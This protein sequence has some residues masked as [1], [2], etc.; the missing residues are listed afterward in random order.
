MGVHIEGDNPDWAL[1]FVPKGR[2]IRLWVYWNQ[3]ELSPY[4]YNFEIL[5]RKFSLFKD[6]K[7]ILSLRNAPEWNRLYPERGE[8]S[9]PNKL[10]YVNFS[11]IIGKRYN[12]YGLE[13]WNEPEPLVT[14]ELSHFIGSFSDT[15]EGGKIYAELVKAV[16]EEY[17]NNNLPHKI[18]SGALAISDKV[19]TFWNSAIKNNINSYS[20]A[21]SFHS[22]PNLLLDYS[23]T[24]NNYNLI[25]SLS[26][27]KELLLT[28]T[29]YLY[30]S[31]STTNE[32]KQAEYL[33]Y[34][35]ERL[36]IIIIWYTLGRNGWRNS[37][38][39][40]LDMR[41]KPVYYSFVE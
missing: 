31:T 34:I 29:S 5:D 8:G 9:P 37:D 27:G 32:A 24:I 22:Y 4:N 33:Q 16:Y 10:E 21:I 39:L 14:G 7:I 35:K 11:K 40:D 26:P 12:F 25:N 28:E 18:I 2:F 30:E 20:D 41:K 1:P 15:E 38:L 3:V 17:K 6:Y 36:N 13:I 19:S 23:F